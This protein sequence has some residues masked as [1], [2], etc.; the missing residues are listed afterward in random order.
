[1]GEDV[2]SGASM[3]R[4]EFVGDAIKLDD[5]DRVIGCYDDY[6]L[7]P[8]YQPIYAFAESNKAKLV[9]Y[10]ALVRPHIG[11]QTIRPDD[12]FKLVSQE[13][14]LF[15]ECLCI[16]VHIAGFRTA[17]LV[18]TGLFVNVNVANYETREEIEREFFY[19]FSQL[20]KHKISRDYIVFEILETRIENPEILLHLCDLIKTN[21]YRFA[22]D[23]F[24]TN[25]SNVDRYMSVNPDIIKLDKS[26]LA[27]AM[28]SSET[29][30]LLQ[31]LVS[32]FQNNGVKVLM[33]GV[34]TQEEL[35]RVE[36]LGMDMIQGF[37]LGT[38]QRIPSLFKEEIELPEQHSK[39]TKMRFAV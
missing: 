18:D 1:L 9:G 28:K 4:E 39:I 21:G 2:G 35:L 27:N 37:Y 17:G 29:S 33:E 23:D 6:I 8:F 10:E 38:P 34:E 26:L 31:S 36:E 7:K 12:F 32:S 5:N 25:H 3:K 20:A 11:N 13:D 16:G 19:I 22:L 15:V 14:A 24:G 30:K